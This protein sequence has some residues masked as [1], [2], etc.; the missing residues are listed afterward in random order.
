MSNINL[1][2]IRDVTVADVPA[3]RATLIETWHATY[4]HILGP[5]KVRDITTR[6][7]SLVALTSQIGNGATFLLAETDGHVLG[8]SYAKREDEAGVVKLYRLY[9][10][11]RAHGSGLG[12]RLMAETFAPYADAHRQRLEVGPQNL[13]AIR[14]YEREGFTEIGEIASHDGIAGV[15]ALVYER[16]IA[17]PQ[18]P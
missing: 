8:S 17:A 4:D 6:W 13:R 10:H 14:F 11:P 1:P 15:E 18:I 5:D 3:V 16:A 2:V 9:I 12:R 7:H